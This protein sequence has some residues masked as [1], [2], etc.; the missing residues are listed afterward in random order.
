MTERFAVYRTFTTDRDLLYVGI[1]KE[2]G[3]RWGEHARSQPW[4]PEARHMTVDWYDDEAEAVRA[5]V[6]AINQ[7]HPRFNVARTNAHYRAQRTVDPGPHEYMGTAEIG[8]ALKVSRQRVQQ[9]TR[10]EDFPEPY[11]SIAAGKI[12]LRADIETWATVH[13][14]ELAG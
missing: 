5:E 14:R 9:I 3:R 6:E 7:E 4:W 1:S 10:T 2:F 13:G 12:W 8:C 11:A